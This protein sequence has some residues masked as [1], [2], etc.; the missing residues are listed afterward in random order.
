MS[1]VPRL[2]VNIL[3]KKS[4]AVPEGNGPTPRDAGKMIIWEE[5]RQE[6]SETWSEA[7]R[8]YKEDLRRMDQCLASLE[9][10]ARQPRLAMEADV[11]ADEKPREHKE[12]AAKEVQAMDEDSFSAN[13]VQA[14]RTTLTSVGVKD[15]SPALPCRDDVLAKN[16]AAAPKSCLSPLEVRTHIHS[17]RWLTP[18]RQ[19]LNSDE[20]HLRPAISLVLPDGRDKFENFKFYM[21]RTTAVSTRVLSPPAGG[22]LKQNRGK[23]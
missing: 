23:T 20:K 3:R 2:S 5:I 10:N 12:S 1:L 11:P 21:P 19:T 22:S 18:H 8:G 4:E 13:R 17:R 14:S 16:G 6:R 15:E 9:Q 7:F